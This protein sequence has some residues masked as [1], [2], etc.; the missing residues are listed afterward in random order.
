MFGLFLFM[1]GC[2]MPRPETVVTERVVRFMLRAPAG[3]KAAGVGDF[4][5]WT[6]EGGSAFRTRCKRLQDGLTAGFLVRPGTTVFTGYHCL[7]RE[8]REPTDFE[9]SAGTF[10]LGLEWEPRAKWFAAVQYDRRASDANLPDSNTTANI[11]SL[12]VRYGY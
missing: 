8:Y 3:P 7:I 6:G 1:I 2:S 11:I 4:N 9:K 12:G 10:S 5:R